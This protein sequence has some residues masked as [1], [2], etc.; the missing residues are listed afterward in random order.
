MTKFS[1]NKKRFINNQRILEELLQLSEPAICVKTE[2][3]DFEDNA[4]DTIDYAYDDFS[5][6]FDDNA[7]DDSVDSNNFLPPKE[8][9]MKK[10]SYRVEKPKRSPIIVNGIKSVNGYFSCDECNNYKTKKATSIQSH[11]WKLHNGPKPVKQF[12]CELCS[13]DF[14]EKQGLKRHLDWH[15]NIKKFFCGKLVN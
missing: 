13:K 4:E 8:I 3:L 5:A 2:I 9:K 10:S 1:N 15:W 7:N 11:K 12:I 6:R 14:R